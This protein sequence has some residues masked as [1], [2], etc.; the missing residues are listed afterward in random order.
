MEKRAAELYKSGF[1]NC[2][3]QVL[4]KTCTAIR[5]LVK[6]NVQAGQVKEHPNTTPPTGPST[7][8]EKQ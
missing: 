6:K 3:V 8:N 7:Y 4:A 5:N 2:E 1:I